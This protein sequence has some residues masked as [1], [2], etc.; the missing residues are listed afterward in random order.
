MS[1]VQILWKSNLLLSSQL[2]CGHSGHFPYNI[3]LRW[4]RQ[5]QAIHKLKISF[6]GIL[7]NLHQNR[8]TLY[9]FQSGQSWGRQSI[10]PARQYGPLLL[11]MVTEDSTPGTKSPG[12][13]R[14]APSVPR[15]VFCNSSLNIRFFP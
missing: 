12:D 6:C 14:K 5:Y 1:S 15:K 7:D 10:S 11:I 2:S 4:P 13:M 3:V 8:S 9:Y